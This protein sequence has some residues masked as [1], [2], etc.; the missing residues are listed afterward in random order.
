MTK[1]SA[2]INEAMSGLLETNEEIRAVGQL[3]SGLNLFWGQVTLGIL[4]IFFVKFWYVAITNKQVLFVKLT[5][6]SKPD[7]NQ[8]YRVPFSDVQIM[9]NGLSVR[10][11]NSACPKYFRFHFGARKL[12]GL[13]K[14][15]FIQALN[16]AR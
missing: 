1:K 8:I 4:T 9:S 14:N 12:T 7:L 13:D 16:S 10:P 3:T 6:L 2:T 15:E 11:T 5:N